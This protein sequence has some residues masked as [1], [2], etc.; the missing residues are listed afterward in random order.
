M[1]RLASLKAATNLHDIAELLGYQAKA[2]SYLLY[3]KPIPSRYSSFT[4]AKRKGGTRVINAPSPEL[5]L[6]QRRLADLLQDC[7]KEISVAHGRSD[8][9]AHGFKRKLSII[10]NAT[11][12]RRRRWVFNVDLEDFFGTIN[13]GRVRG[14]FMKDRDFALPAY[15][16]ALR[17]SSP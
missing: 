3:V 11:G 6:L 10:S 15:L 12:H 2:L 1:V 7:S 14:F 8:R 13:F 5:K 4:I 9:L 16:I 17:Q